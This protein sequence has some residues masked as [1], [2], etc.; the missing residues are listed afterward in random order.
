MNNKIIPCSSLVFDS[1]KANSVNSANN[2]TDAIFKDINFRT[3]LGDSFEL[4]GKYNISVSTI[5]TNKTSGTNMAAGNLNVYF[6]VSSPAMKFKFFSYY[7]SN[8]VDFTNQTFFMFPHRYTTQDN[9]SYYSE[10]SM[11]SFELVGEIADININHYYANTT[12]TSPS[13]NISYPYLM[14]CDIYKIK[15]NNNRLQIYKHIMLNNKIVSLRLATTDISI[16][17]TA[18]DYPLT[19]SIGYLDTYR[20]EMTFKNV[21][22]RQIIGPELFEKYDMFNICLI[23]TIYNANTFGTNAIDKLIRIEMKGLPWVN[24]TYSTN[25]N[26]NGE[27]SVMGSMKMNTT[28]TTQNYS[29]ANIATFRKCENIDLTIRFIRYDGVYATTT[30][31]FPKIEM[32]FKIYPA[33]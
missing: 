28:A 20:D 30:G 32:Y 9:I 4:G 26:Y 5:L 6:L 12:S 11:C 24:N 13:N 19:N 33:I 2:H 27:Y 29:Y 23:H 3:L 8:S 1:N 16:S 10:V 14:I 7:N 17:D 31:L 15:E 21:N 25:S 22:I 18:G